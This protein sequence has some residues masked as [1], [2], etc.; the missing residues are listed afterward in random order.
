MGYCFR[1][2]EFHLN[3]HLQGRT[4]GYSFLLTTTAAPAG[5]GRH[6]AI[7]LT[8]A[9]PG[10]TSPHGRGAQRGRARPRR[11]GGSAGTAPARLGLAL[12]AGPA[13]GRPLERPGGA[14]GT[15][16]EARSGVRVG[17]AGWVVCGRAVPARVKTVN[18]PGV[19]EQAL[20]VIKALCSSAPLMPLKHEAP[21]G[22]A[23]AA[24]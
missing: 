4:A 2:L 13:R 1:L 18:A 9:R 16:G 11:R 3:G 22:A 20:K 23:A 10:R 24:A 17:V 15:G 5:R 6:N 7:Y 19:R 14:A 12:R 21:Q 8:A